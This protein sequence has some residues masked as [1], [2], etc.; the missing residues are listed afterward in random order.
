MLSF[1]AVFTFSAINIPLNEEKSFV[2]W[3][4]STN[5]IYTGAEYK[6]RLGIYL[7]NQKFVREHNANPSKTFKVEM[8]KFAALTPS[9]YKSLLG[10][11]QKALKN[12]KRAKIVQNNKNNDKE[13]DWRTKG[14]VNKI[15]NQGSCGSCW[16]FSAIQNCE[17]AEFLKYNIL[18]RFSEQSLVDCVTADAGCSGG[19]PC[20]AYTYIVEECQGK[21]MLEDDYPYEAIDAKCRFDI[22]K[23]IGHFTHYIEIESGSESDLAAK[24]EKYGPLSIGIDASQMSFQLY[25]GGIYDEPHCSSLFLDHG[26]GLVGYGSENGVQYWIVRNSWGEFW[27]E[28]G[29]VRMIRGSNQCGEATSATCIISE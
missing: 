26:V 11:N 29:Y 7:A 15:K 19:L 27:G 5:N 18:Y 16:A 8:N 10:F 6:L 20:D 21:V 24:C 14:A 12:L 9:E 4:R 23:A 1:L 22:N 3:M 2:A 13:L 28:K 17:S 25:A